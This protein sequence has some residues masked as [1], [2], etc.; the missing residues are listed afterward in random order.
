MAEFKELQNQVW[1]HAY[2]KSAS[3]ETVAAINRKKR[4]NEPSYPGTC[5]KKKQSKKVLK[6]QNLDCNA[7]NACPAGPAGSPGEPGQDG[8]PGLPA[9]PGAPGLPGNYPPV[10]VDFSETKCRMCPPGPP[11]YPGK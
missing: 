4:Q 2:G 3:Q 1:T 5:S 9:V 6:K 8:D 11:G 7:Q 10:H